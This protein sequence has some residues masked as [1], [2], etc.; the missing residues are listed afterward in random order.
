[1]VHLIAHKLSAIAFEIGGKKIS[2][3]RSSGCGAERRDR[4][5]GESQ[6]TG[7]R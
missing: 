3:L 7:P 1:M 5:F 4:R 2:V 6:P